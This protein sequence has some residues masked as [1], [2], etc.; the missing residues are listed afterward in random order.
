M[1]RTHRLSRIAWASLFALSLV[2]ACADGGGSDGGV[3][4]GGSS[5]GGSDGGSS[6]AADS[7]SGGMDRDGEEV[8]MLLCASCHGADA[9]GT[10]L[11]YELRHP[12]RDYAAWVVRNGRTGNELAPSVMAAYPSSVVTDIELERVFD[13]LDGFPRAQ[14]GE[15]LYLDH[16]RNCHGADAAGGEVQKD[17]RPNPFNDALEK[18]R[19]G[20]G[21][22]NYGARLLF[23]PSLDAEALSDDELQQIVDYIGT[24]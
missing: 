4:L 20:E 1:T 13:F 18:T 3:T 14:G 17:I 16:C 9:Q 2:A 19:Q 12:V 23:M 5:G 24:L 11:A 8:Y 7:G 15:A 6:S 10:M 22:T 21:G